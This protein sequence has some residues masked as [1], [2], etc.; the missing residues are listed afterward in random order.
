MT[1]THLLDLD[2]VRGRWWLP[3]AV[4]YHRDRHNNKSA[5]A[6]S[7]QWLIMEAFPNTGWGGGML[8]GTNK[9]AYP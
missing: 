4:L 5:H 6:T 9:E 8:T 3:P 7:A 2:K 1:W